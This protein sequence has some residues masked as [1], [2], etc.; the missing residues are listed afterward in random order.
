MPR[1]G[2]G[3]W[4]VLVAAGVAVSADSARAQDVHWRQDYTAARKEATATGRPLLL[5]FGTEACVWC[6]KLDATTFRDRGVVELINERVIPVK[7]DGEREAWLTRAAG[8]EAFPT[9]VLVSPDGKIVARH[10]GYADAAKM[11]AL[12]RQV[13]PREAPAARP[14][15]RSPAAELLALA[16][17]D[18]DAGR[19]LACIERC[20]RLMSGYAAGP[21]AGEAR[22]LSAAITGDPEK[23][24]RVTTQID[25]DFAAVKRDLDVA[26][27]R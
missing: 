2:G 6:R 15:E 18:H 5:D 4:A 26:L 23:W 3:I 14:P 20:D 8:V 17:A 22:R 1:T 21:E 7:V 9:L 12:L 25:T 13:A 27:K 11:T 10:E 24:R 19:Y 16:R